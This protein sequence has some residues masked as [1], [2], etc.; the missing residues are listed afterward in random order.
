[1]S[2]SGRC[3]PY[4]EIVN[5]VNFQVL[6]KNKESINL[7]SYYQY[8]QFTPQGGGG[9]RAQGPK[10]KMIIE[11]NTDLKL[12]SDLYFRIKHRGNFKNKLICRFGINPAFIK[13]K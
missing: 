6:W 10:Q 1:V 5:G 4:V 8:D 9:R 11:I 12:S 13:S 3:K 2:G 7:K